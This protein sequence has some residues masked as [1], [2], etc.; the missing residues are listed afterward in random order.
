MLQDS[1]S[2]LEGRPSV[3]L[4]GPPS[5][6]EPSTAYRLTQG[7]IDSFHENGFLAVDAI[8]TPEEVERLREIFATLLQSRAGFE[9]GA[10]FDLTGSGTHIRP[11][12]VVQIMN[13]ANYVPELR[14]T[15]FRR[16]A[17]AIADQLIG[18]ASAFFEHAIVKPAAGSIATPWHQ[19]EAYRDDADLEYRELSIWLPLQP[20]T[21]ES[22]CMQFLPGTHLG[23][24]RR[25]RPIGGSSSA[26]ALECTEVPD[27]G[28]AVACPL[29]AG[30][31]TIHGGRTLHYTGP[32][33]SAFPRW[34]YVLCFDVPP[35][36]RLQAREFSWNIDRQTT[37]SLRRR[38]WLQ[39]GGFP[40]R[41]QT[42]NDPRYRQG[43]DGDSR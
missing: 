12:S 36:P 1:I 32:N 4:F 11:E 19:D 25:H 15:Q 40:R 8:T 14:N 28:R 18:K 5:L 30:G 20:V 27:S 35:R 9:E 31:C 43:S 24:L 22:G 42:G 23:E 37:D 34:A 38:R 41:I 39:H 33:Q 17:E 13:P 26:H 3:R 10:Q 29:L 21:V 6:Q 7:E 2:T 16:N